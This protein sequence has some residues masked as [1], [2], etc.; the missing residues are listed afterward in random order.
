MK[1]SITPSGEEPKLSPEEQQIVNNLLDQWNLHNNELKKIE[2]QINSTLS[3]KSD[4]ENRDEQ[5]FNEPIIN[6]LPQNPLFTKREEE[7][8]EISR[9]QAEISKLTK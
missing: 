6:N 2:A 9:L 5:H 3:D 1:E 7:R 4:S 8:M